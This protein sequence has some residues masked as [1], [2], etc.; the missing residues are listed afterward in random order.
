MKFPTRK[1]SDIAGYFDAYA[2]EVANALALVDRKQLDL[3]RQILVDT[4]KRDGQ[5]FACGNGGSAA[6]ANHLQCDH[7]KGV[8]TSTNLR[9]RVQSL[10]AN[11]EIITAIA[12]DRK[13]AD[14]FSAQLSNAARAGDALMI[15]SASGQSLN[16]CGALEWARNN[17]LKTIALTGFTGGA[18]AS[19]AD[20]CVHVNSEN[21]GVIEDVHQSLMHTL[22][23]FIQ[24]S[25]MDEGA[26][27]KVKF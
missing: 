6:I 5:V 20:V 2:V 24:I 9:P 18:A 10:S 11:I 15:I 12:N 27:G 1:Y 19:L 3:A 13:F 23:Q 16:V 26:V 14:I 8:S 4:I 21:Y 7:A 22:A 25:N 17:G